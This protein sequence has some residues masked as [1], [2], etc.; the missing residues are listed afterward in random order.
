MQSLICLTAPKLSFLCRRLPFSN[1]PGFKLTLFPLRLSGAGAVPQSLGTTEPEDTERLQ[2]LLQVVKDARKASG[3]NSVVGLRGPLHLALLISPLI[4]ASHSTLAKYSYNRQHVLTSAHR[5]GNAK[6]P[7]LQCVE[8]LMWE[9]LILLVKG[10]KD[11]FEVLKWLV[12]TL[13]WKEIENAAGDQTER[14]WFKLGTFFVSS[15]DC[16]HLIIS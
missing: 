9:G 3:S 1:L 11:P 4:L 2:E 5:L 16:R 7:L 10:E 6:S 14:A 12:D 8:R 13:P 15:S